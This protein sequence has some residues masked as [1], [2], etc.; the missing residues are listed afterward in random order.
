MD[1]AESLGAA[2]GVGGVS[3]RNSCA[4]LISA[5]GAGPAAADTLQESF[6][7]STELRMF[8]MQASHI[9]SFLRFAAFHRVSCTSP[10]VCF[11]QP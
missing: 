7:Q 9:S 3:V 1:A 5:L 4:S 6:S 2:G 11:Q 8:K 10:V